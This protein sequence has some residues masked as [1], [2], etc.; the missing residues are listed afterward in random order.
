MTSHPT[1]GQGHAKVTTGRDV[2]MNDKFRH[3]CSD[4]AWLY[5]I[6]TELESNDVW[7]WSEPYF[8]PLMCSFSLQRDSS[9]HRHKQYKLGFC[10]DIPLSA[11][12]LLSEFLW[13]KDYT[14]HWLE[15][16]RLDDASRRLCWLVCGQKMAPSHAACQRCWVILT[17]YF[18]W[19]HGW[20]SPQTISARWL[21][22]PRPR[23]LLSYDFGKSG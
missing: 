6:I 4:L 16:P 5:L 22:F 15:S 19:V 21:R 11:K 12:F 3:C 18:T 2:K 8:P 10:T 7:I 13:V 9:P 20:Q 14:N 23:L 17:N 1:A